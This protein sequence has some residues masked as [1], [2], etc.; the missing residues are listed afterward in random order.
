[1]ADTTRTRRQK[2][3][4]TGPDIIAL[5]AEIK[6]ADFTELIFPKKLDLAKRV[7]NCI[8]NSKEQLHTHSEL[9]IMAKSL[10]QKQLDA[11]KNFNPKTYNNIQTKFK[12]L[13][14][15][16]PWMQRFKEKRAVLMEKS[17]PVFS[18]SHLKTG[19]Q[20]HDWTGHQDQDQGQ[21]QDQAQ[22]EEDQ[23]Q[24]QDQEAQAQDQ[25]AQAQDQAQDQQ[26]TSTKALTPAQLNAI[27]QI[28]KSIKSAGGMDT[29]ITPY[30]SPS[31]LELVRQR[32]HEIGLI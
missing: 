19:Y 5:R 22:K 18:S 30:L 21:G 28:L 16:K 4:C 25:E 24:A 7:Q 32:A 29:V 27:I 23:A 2:T 14:A 12:T 31:N 3:E 8:K 26:K 6:H 9:I 15:M 20:Y 10:L 11:G 1:M 17:K 13:P